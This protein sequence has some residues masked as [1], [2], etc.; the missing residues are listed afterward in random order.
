M[1]L[2]IVGIDN[3]MRRHF[4][5]AEASTKWNLRRIE[6]ALG[7]NYTHH[8]LDIRDE[9]AIEALFRHHGGN[10]SLVIHA[11]AQPSHEWAAQH[12]STDFAVNA[13]GTLN[14][15]EATRKYAPEAVFIHLSTNKVYGDHPNSLPLVEHESRW[16]IA[17]EHRFADGIDETMSIDD[18]VHSL[19]GASKTAADLL[20]QEY[21]RYYGLHTT[22]FRAGCLTGPGH[23]GA[24][25]HGFLAYLMRCAATGRHYTVIGHQGKQVRDNLHC[26][27][28]V[29]AFAAVF[30]DP[31]V[32]EV[33]N[34]GGS[35]IS[36]C[37]ILEAIDGCEA[38]CGHAMAWSYDPQPRRG[39][40]I[41]WISDN[42][43]FEGRYPEWCLRH[44]T[45]TILRQIY[46]ENVDRW[47][48]ELRR[49]Q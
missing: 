6:A 21:G 10:V 43:R 35:R 48:T 40:H 36:N 33:F 11:A 19:F 8:D 27:D 41:W 38:I 5:G 25:L 39:D 23:A 44:D 45:S 42:G 18:C 17:P 31:G 1:G 14:L 47:G 32:G 9:E 22:A 16:E 34:I 15:L 37:S 2:D 26:A 12:P 7:N 4:F 3:D 30:R 46:E 28:L 49:A 24:E 29:A 20:V 13:G